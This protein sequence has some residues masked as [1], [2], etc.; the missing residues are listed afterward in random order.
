MSPELNEVRF[1][2]SVYSLVDTARATPSPCPLDSPYYS[3]PR[4]RRR[5][6][7]SVPVN[8]PPCRMTTSIPAPAA[9]TSPHLTLGSQLTLSL[10]TTFARRE[11]RSHPRSR[12]SSTASS[13]WSPVSAPLL[14]HPRRSRRR[15]VLTASA[16]ARGYASSKNFGEFTVLH[17][18]RIS[19]NAF[20]SP[21]SRFNVITQPPRR[22]RPGPAFPPPLPPRRELFDF[23]ARD[24]K[25]GGRLAHFLSARSIRR[26]VSRMPSRSIVSARCASP[27]RRPRCPPP[28]RCG[29]R[30]RRAS[31]RRRAS[32]A[33]RGGEGEERRAHRARGRA[34]TSRSTSRVEV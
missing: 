29:G 8:H 27:R 14:F 17:P 25:L 19:F 21:S 10:P 18:R 30:A 9:S 22:R 31:A 1:G 20:K 23:F 26:R 7:S 4:A 34:S 28:E 3:S 24:A 33:T 11:Y 13:A 5:R 6:S 2:P 12:T 15:R 16:V 32:R